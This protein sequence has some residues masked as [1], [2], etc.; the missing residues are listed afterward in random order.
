MI[1]VKLAVVSLGINTL[2]GP[3][4]WVPASLTKPFHVK[5][6]AAARCD[7]YHQIGHRKCCL[8]V[9]FM[10]KIWLSKGTL[11]FLILFTI[12]MI[13]SKNDMMRNRRLR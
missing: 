13:L 3:H 6:Q 12:L 9:D 4:S 10:S 5:P 1:N 2:R 7:I 8:I 11:G